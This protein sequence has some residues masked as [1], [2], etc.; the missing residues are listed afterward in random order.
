MNLCKQICMW[1]RECGCTRKAERKA[2]RER[3]P[4]G[5][6]STGTHGLSGKRPCPLRVQRKRETWGRNA[7]PFKFSFSLFRI[8]SQFYSFPLKTLEVVI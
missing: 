8:L 2:T 3:V 5:P 6:A 4:E 1:E 7:V